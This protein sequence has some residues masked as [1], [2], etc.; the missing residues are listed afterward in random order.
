MADNF[1]ERQRRDYEERKQQWLKNKRTTKGDNVAS[2]M[3]KARERF[4]ND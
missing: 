3:K 2:I 4:N 1:L